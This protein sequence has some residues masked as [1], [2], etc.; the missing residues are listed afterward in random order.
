M[1]SENVI[2]S[3]DLDSIYKIP[4]YLH[5]QGLDQAVVDQLNIWTRSPNLDQWKHI[6]KVLDSAEKSCTIGVVGKYV[7]VIDSYKSI[8]ETLIHAGI[9]NNAKVKVQY[10]DATTLNDENVENILGSMDGVIVPGGL[11]NRGIEGKMVA[12]KYLRE[13]KKPFLDLL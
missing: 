10:V 4:M 3:C 6:V 12:I 5:E 7:D 1:K 13:N 8:N 9:A 2:D 11:G